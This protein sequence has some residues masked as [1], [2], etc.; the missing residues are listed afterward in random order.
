MSTDKQTLAREVEI[1]QVKTSSMCRLVKQ[2]KVETEE[3][4]NRFFVL[5]HCRNCQKF[6]EEDI[7]G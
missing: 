6:S 7:S 1:E 4:R 3:L 5:T 2:V